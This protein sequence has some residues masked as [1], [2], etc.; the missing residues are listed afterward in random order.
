LSV[1]ILHAADFHMDSPFYSLPEDKSAQRRREQRELLEKVAAAAKS[2]G[3]Q[4]VLLAGDLF[5]SN[6]SYWET[7]E[8]LTRV[9]SEIDAHIFISPGNHDFY[10]SRSPYAFMD[11]PDNVHIFKTTAIKCYELPDLNCRVW[12]AGFSSASC[13]SLL[14][15]FSAPQSDMVDIMVMHGDIMGGRYNPI[16]EANIAASK[17]DYLALGHI[18]AFSG[19]L[20]AG[21]TSYAYPGCLEGR[22]FDELGQKGVIVGS[23]SKGETDLHFLPIEGRQ[24]RMI[25]VDLTDSE[26]A[27]KTADKAIGGG[28]PQDIARIVFR[29]E[30]S[31]IL[32]FDEI[33]NALKGRFYHL[34]LKNETRPKRGIWEGSDEDSLT[35]LFLSKLKAR[36]ESA[37]SDEE[38]ELIALAA[39]Y[40]LAALEDREEWHP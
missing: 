38:R 22:G 31:G 4:I 13:E 27:L 21:N 36:Y 34:T 14:G 19:I 32:D 12:G 24:Y 17:L 3:A 39:R 37:N 30:Y 28:F 5:D 11:L 16:T 23:V 29:G 2:E 15:S 9:L 33:L 6:A 20:K 10:T 26:D 40:G 7:S 25:D 8:T 1:K 18:H 35:G